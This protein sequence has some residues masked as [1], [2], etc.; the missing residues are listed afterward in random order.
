MRI[1]DWSSD[2]CSSDL[3]G[4]HC[5]EHREELVLARRG[6][7]ALGGSELF[8]ARHPWRVHVGQPE[9]REPRTILAAF[10]KLERFVDEAVGDLRARQP[11]D[12]AP[13]ELG[14]LMPEPVGAVGRMGRAACRG[15]VVQIRL[16]PGGRML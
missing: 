2:V 5:D 15:R 10:Y 13:S 7:L 11:F 4:I 8:G 9:L 16:D 14:A 12:R 6:A 1:S 3:L